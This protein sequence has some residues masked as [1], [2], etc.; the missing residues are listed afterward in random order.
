M[1]IAVCA[2]VTPDTAAQIKILRRRSTFS[3]PMREPCRQEIVGAGAMAAFALI[4]MPVADETIAPR[5]GGPTRWL[6]PV[7]HEQ[8]LYH[9]PRGLGTGRESSFKRQPI[10]T[11][12]QTAA[13]AWTLPS[14]NLD[15]HGLAANIVVA[16]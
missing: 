16:A 2:K 3:D 9:Y 10:A 1:N 14:K 11:G 4:D 12:D 8:R 15:R 13:A 7:Q 6:V 5:V